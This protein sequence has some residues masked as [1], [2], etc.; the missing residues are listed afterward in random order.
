MFL[1]FYNAYSYNLVE[2]F[3]S[4]FDFGENGTPQLQTPHSQLQTCFPS[5]LN[6]LFRELKA[7]TVNHEP[8]SFCQ[9]MTANCQLIKP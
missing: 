4:F 6:L 1:Y 3:H 2:F 8:F 9:L 5:T 7:I